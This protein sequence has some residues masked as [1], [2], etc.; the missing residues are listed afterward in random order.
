MTISPAIA[1]GQQCLSVVGHDVSPFKSAPSAPGD[2]AVP[3]VC[4]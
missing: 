4:S 3:I 1:A 2:A